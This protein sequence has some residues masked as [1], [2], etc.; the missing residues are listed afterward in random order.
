M[1]LR[2]RCAR[3]MA[4][5]AWRALPTGFHTVRAVAVAEGV[6]LRVCLLPRSKKIAIPN[7]VHLK[8]LSWNME[9]GWIACGGENGL[10]KPRQGGPCTKHV[11]RPQVQA[12][13]VCRGQGRPKGHYVHAC[14]RLRAGLG[15]GRRGRPRLEAGTSMFC[16]RIY[17]PMFRMRVNVR[18]GPSH[19]QCRRGVRSNIC[20][21][22][23]SRISGKIIYRIYRI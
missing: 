3:L 18:T 5:C 14:P 6:R 13:C 1:L 12:D 8:C 19:T 4:R 10:L 17:L 2:R 11:S 7:N 21:D 16:A 20:R 22:G 15:R 9:H 23:R